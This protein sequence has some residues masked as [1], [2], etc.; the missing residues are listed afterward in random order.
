MELAVISSTETDRRIVFTWE[1]EMTNYILQK[2]VLESNTKA[3]YTIIWGQCSE[4][5]RAKVKSSSGYVSKSTACDCKWLLKTIHGI[6]LCFNGQRKIHHFI[7]NAH[8]A[9]HAYR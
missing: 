3:A 4:A 9:Y 5:L 8:G 7:S 2:N 1:K 6:M